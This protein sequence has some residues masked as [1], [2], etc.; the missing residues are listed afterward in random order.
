MRGPVDLKI[1][2]RL[3]EVRKLAGVTQTELA[4]C[5]GVTQG[6]IEHYENGR[7]RIPI[8]RF[9]TIA[10]ALHCDVR[11]LHEQPA[12]SPRHA[13]SI[14]ASALEIAAA[15]GA[16]PGWQSPNSGGQKAFLGV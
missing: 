7:S 2:R 11:Q 12:L 8:H 4:H 13:G 15:I 10:A 6:L 9:E 16:R 1:A 5:L 14:Q 3:R